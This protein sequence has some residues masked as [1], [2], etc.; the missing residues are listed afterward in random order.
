M[1]VCADRGSVPMCMPVWEGGQW[2][3]VRVWS[4]TE[5]ICHRLCILLSAPVHTVILPREH[6]HGHLNI[7]PTSR[8]L[9]AF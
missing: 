1:Q 4:D 6:V 7:D 8:D 5:S 9:W 2:G 3:S